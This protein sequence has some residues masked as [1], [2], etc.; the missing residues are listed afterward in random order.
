MVALNTALMTGGVALRVGEGVTLD[1]PIHV[2]HLDGTGE[3]ASIFTRDP[4]DRRA[5]QR[6][7]ADRKLLRVLGCAGSSATP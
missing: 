6:A 3:P 1:K 2:I 7:D 4:R 5:R